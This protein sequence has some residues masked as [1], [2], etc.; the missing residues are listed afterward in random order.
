L[1]SILRREGAS[2]P[3]GEINFA[4]SLVPEIAETVTGAFKDD[5]VSR[6]V[7]V[8]LSIGVEDLDAGLSVEIIGDTGTIDDAG[9]RERVVGVD[10]SD[11]QF[12]RDTVAVTVAGETVFAI[13]GIAEPVLI[14]LFAVFDHA[15]FEVS[16]A[17][18]IGSGAKFTGRKPVLTFLHGPEIAETVTGAFFD[19]D[20]SVFSNAAVCVFVEDSNI[21]VR[22]EIAADLRFGQRISFI[23]GTVKVSFFESEGFFT[24]V[25]ERNEPCSTL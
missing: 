17:R 18:I 2:F 10:K 14:A 23:E 6:V 21:G 19:D 25:I 5:F 9:R 7:D 20:L 11:N 13:L 22:I 15:S 8:S 4:R 3:G 1:A 24:L 16:V 12:G